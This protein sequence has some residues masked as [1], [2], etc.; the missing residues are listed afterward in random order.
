MSPSPTSAAPDRVRPGADVASAMRQ[1]GGMRTLTSRTALTFAGLALLAGGLA[2]CG[3]SDSGGGSAGAES[4]AMPS[5]ASASD[6]C[7]SFQSLRD[8]LGNLDP[9]ADPSEIVKTV[10]DAADRIAQTGVP[11]DAPSQAQHGLEVTLEAIQGL[12]AN[13]KLKDISGLETS[14][15][16]SDKADA[17]AFDTY[18]AKTCP[19]LS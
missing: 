17:Q 16:D 19:D 1:G 11:S 5:D 7:A 4:T 10:Q 8:D 9:S 18:L 12:P 15:S 14:L 3:G 13:A 2:G 6:F